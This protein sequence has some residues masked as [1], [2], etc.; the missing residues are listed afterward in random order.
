M[1][2]THKLNEDFSMY[3]PGKDIL[4]SFGLNPVISATGTVTAY[5]VAGSDQKSWML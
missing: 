4:E 1:L 2:A 5:G 3:D